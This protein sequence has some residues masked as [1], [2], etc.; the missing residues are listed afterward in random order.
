MLSY[1]RHAAVILSALG[2]VG[3]SAR[4][5]M[6]GPLTAHQR[7][8]GPNA[9]T[10]QQET[11]LAENFTAQLKGGLDPVS[12]LTDPANR[13]LAYDLAT[14][15]LRQTWFGTPLA[16]SPQRNTF[17]LHTRMRELKLYKGDNTA[18]LAS[19]E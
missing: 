17:L 11:W 12:Q 4:A 1:V 7:I 15:A 8:S 19:Y 10:A 16:A 14:G 3:L 13:L 2:A 6:C 5:Q 9:V 18:P